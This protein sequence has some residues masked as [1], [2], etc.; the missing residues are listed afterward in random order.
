VTCQ[1]VELSQDNYC[2]R[3]MIRKASDI[4][5]PQDIVNNNESIS[6]SVFGA[7]TISVGT[8]SN[9]CIGHYSMISVPLEPHFG[10]VGGKMQ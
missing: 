3:E 7:S 1:A 2:L 5:I 8:K 6:T 10:V 9:E 4:K